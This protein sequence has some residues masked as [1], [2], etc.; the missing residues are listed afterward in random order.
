MD[1]RVITEASDVKDAV[2]RLQR[3]LD[4]EPL[5]A[6]DCETYLAGQETIYGFK[7]P[8]TNKV[9]IVQI[10]TRTGL[11]YLFDIKAL[12]EKALGPLI[13]L[14]RR[15]DVVWIAHNMKFDWKMLAVNLNA[16]LKKIYC[17]LVAAK[18]LGHATGTSARGAAGNSLKDL[19]RDFL[20]L[21]I[22]KTE[23][24][25]YWGGSLTKSQL[26]Y[27]A[28]DVVH[29]I[30]LYDIFVTAFEEDYQCTEAVSL[31]M[32]VLP[33]VCKMELNGIPLDVDMYRKVQ[34]CAQAAIP[35]LLKELCDHFDIKMQRTFN[36]ET[37]KFELQ[38]AKMNF[39]STKEVQALFHRHG[40]MVE[41][42]Q[43]ETLRAFSERFPILDTFIKYKKLAKQLSVDYEAYIHPITGRIHPTFDQ[44]GAATAR[45]S[46]SEPNLQQVPKIDITVPDHLVDPSWGTR[47]FDKDKQKYLLNYRYCFRASPG[48]VMA[49]ADFS[50]QEVAVMVVL[51][52]DP[53]MINVLNKPQKVW[54]DEKQKYV[55]NLEADLHSQIAAEMFAVKPEEARNKHPKFQGV[56]Y[57]DLAK[58]RVF[59]LAYG[60]TEHSVAEELG[61]P[62]E[63]ARKII[64]D[65]FKP[66]PVL[67]RWLDKMAAFAEKTRT[68]VFGLGRIRFLGDLPHKDKGAIGRAGRNTPIQGTSALMMKKSLIEIDLAIEERFGNMIAWTLLC[69]SIHDE[70]L[71]EVPLYLF[72]KPDYNETLLPT[73]R[74]ADYPPEHRGPARLII[75]AMDRG[76][77]FFLKGIVPDRASCGIGETWT[78]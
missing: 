47:Y 16:R 39:N 42:T 6:I 49:S 26:D 3:E 45:F 11:P 60:A 23:Q 73:D 53:F 54:S 75:S 31:E 36:P 78:K 74:Y 10:K 21:P 35:A 28:A 1:Y 34:L 33:V 58:R 62:V 50:G 52:G 20:D 70:A 37:K 13:A 57:R 61:I 56:T 59:G 18:I 8:Y 41:D 77:N 22:D 25:S 7:D 55:D 2:E 66:M 64:R 5:A 32:E 68:T 29:L 46:S 19:I 14:L 67:K 4:Q 15:P 44:T 9:R 48:C 40:I 76:S 43:E 27:A 71:C 69:A 51:S 17:T 24:K 12:P 30:P 63:E 65:F 72:G 38:P